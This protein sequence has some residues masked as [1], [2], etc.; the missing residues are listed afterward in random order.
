LWENE[1]V[2]DVHFVFLGAAI[3]LV[4]SFLYARDT[5]RGRTQ[6]NR[7]TWTLWSAAPML[8][9]AAEL[10]QGVGLQSLMT[11]SVGLGP[12]FVLCASFANKNSVWKIGP[13]D[14]A[15]GVASILGLLLWL[16]TSNNLVA[17]ASFMAADG[18]AGLPTVVKSWTN[19][20][21][22]SASAYIGGF[23]NA[24]LT[25]A[26]VTTW[27]T[28]VVAFPLQIVIFNVVQ[29]I[30]IMGR[31]GPRVCGTLPVAS[32]T[33]SERIIAPTKGIEP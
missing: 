5:F 21:S 11:L 1:W 30:L 22:E 9:F 2:I 13:F 28:A 25:L 12:F 8:A 20:E 15:C 14:L 3:S 16:I 17:L 19:P 10:Q 27:T 7:V 32:Q 31:I 23:V 6:P 33:P 29:T 18:L 26:T 4:G 24:L